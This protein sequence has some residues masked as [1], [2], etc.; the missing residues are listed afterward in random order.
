MNNSSTSSIHFSD[1]I[2]V[3]NIDEE[4]ILDIIRNAG[5]ISKFGL[6]D[7]T[8]FS[9]SKIN[10]HIESLLQK[11]FI[12]DTGAGNYTGGRRSVQ[13]GLN[14]AMGLV[15]GVD[16]GATSIDLLISDLSGVALVRFSEPAIVS[17]GPLVILG[18]VCDLLAR[19]ITENGLTE[20]KLLGI[21]IGV[22]GPVN[23]RLGVLVSP[24]IMPGWDAFPIIPFIRERFPDTVVV[25]D[26]DVNIMALGEHHKGI[27]VGADN[28]IFV[29]IGT[30]I[31]AGII[32]EGKIYRGTDGCAGDIGHICVD[33]N[34]PICTCGNTGCLEAMAGGHAIAIRAM[35][36]VQK[37]EPTILSKYLKDQNRPLTCEDIG[38]AAK[39]GDA[40]AI[41][42][43]R[44]SGRLVGEVLAGL[45]NFFNPQIIVIGGGASKLGN[46]LLTSI[47]RMVL[48]R[49]LPLA[50]SN[51]SIALSPITDDVGVWGAVNLAMNLILSS[52]RPIRISVQ[53]PEA[54]FR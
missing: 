52:N 9:R 29:K 26:N 8:G 11:K 7:H 12:D 28:L 18:R 15:L 25:V 44:D 47:R 54:I 19:L 46:V 6:V 41:E 34:G 39:E 20:R 45:V 27:G 53:Q 13:F 5:V 40:Y 4:R 22:P 49:S 2:P 32:C 35:Q 36:A 1:S 37:G 23:F 42:L 50:T 24:P 3:L 16:I 51:L 38:N 14:G 31:G 30:G 48:K 43:I 17:Q 33:Q 21:G 10:Q